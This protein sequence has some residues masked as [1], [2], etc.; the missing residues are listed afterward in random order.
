MK[1]NTEVF[2][3]ERKKKK[4]FITTGILLKE[5]SPKLAISSKA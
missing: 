3:T 5:N 2:F 4:P 1:K